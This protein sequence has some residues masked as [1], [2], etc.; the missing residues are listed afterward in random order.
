MSASRD[1]LRDRVISHLGSREAAQALYGATVGLALVLALQRQPPA[2]GTVA[3]LILGTAL[4]I[5][6]AELY[7]EA[8]STEARTRQPIHRKQLLRIAG[9]TTAVVFGAGFPAVFFVI[10]TTGLIDTDAAFT[11]SKWGGLTLI[12]GYGFLAGRLAGSSVWRALWHA[13]LIG[14]IGVLLIAG[15]SL[16]H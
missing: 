14:V 8:V 11:L 5:G 16:L 13:A 12:C 10:A 7:A 2:P 6:L 15:K 4:A 3:A 9:R 1:I